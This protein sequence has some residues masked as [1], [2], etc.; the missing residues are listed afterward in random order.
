MLSMYVHL[1]FA[2]FRFKFSFIATQGF[3]LELPEDPMP[4]EFF[5]L[6]ASCWLEVNS[7]AFCLVSSSS[8]L[9]DPSQ[10]PTFSKI[11]ADLFGFYSE[12]QTT[13]PVERDIGHAISAL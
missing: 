10:R 2:V 11:K 3:R 7:W 4:Q 5:D 1:R 9:Q 12:S 8:L 13:C 6:A